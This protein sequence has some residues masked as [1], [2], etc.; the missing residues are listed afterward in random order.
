MIDIRIS[1]ALPGFTLDAA[2]SSDSG[3][4][5]LFGRSGSGKTTLINAIAGL[6]KPDS[7]A[8]TV[9]G[10]CLFDRMRGIDVPVQR[11]RIGYVFQ[12]GR[13]FPHLTVRTNLRY[14]YELANPAARQ[15]GFDHVVGFA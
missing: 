2:F 4:T 5:A 3:I 10:V 13:L 15:V 9:N 1:R 12:D 14:G 6:E 8:I 11:R 7:G